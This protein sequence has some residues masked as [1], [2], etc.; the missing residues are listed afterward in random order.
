MQRLGGQLVVAGQMI[1]D[2]T[3]YRILAGA[4][5]TEGE[6]KKLLQKFTDGYAP[7]VIREK[8]KEPFGK[9]EVYDAEYDFSSVMEDG[10]RIEP[11][12]RRRFFP[13]RSQMRAAKMFARRCR[14]LL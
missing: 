10:F 3:K 1:N 9:I 2:N 13:L 5:E 11:S 4:F 12:A 7:R 14:F 6:A 8:V